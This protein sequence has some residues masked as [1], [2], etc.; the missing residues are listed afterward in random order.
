VTITRTEH[1]ERDNYQH[2]IWTV[3]SKWYTS[4]NIW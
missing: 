3:Q 1:R 2:Q 4:C